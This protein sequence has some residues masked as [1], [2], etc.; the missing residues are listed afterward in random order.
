MPLHNCQ[1]MKLGQ[2]NSTMQDRLNRVHR[3]WL[4]LH[5]GDDR[6][7][8]ALDFVKFIY[9]YLLL[10]RVEQQTVEMVTSKIKSFDINMFNFYRD[11]Q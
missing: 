5:T 3:A 11:N 9:C 8:Q 7:L 6:P 2:R 1:L 4:S 10:I